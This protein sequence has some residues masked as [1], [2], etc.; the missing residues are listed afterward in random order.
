MPGNF[1]FFPCQIEGD[2]AFVFVDVDAKDD[3]AKAPGTLVRVRLMYQAPRANGLP[4]GAEFD[5]ARAIEKSLERFAQRARDRY[6]GRIT[7]SGFREFHVYSRQSKAAWQKFL[8]GLTRRSGY[9]LRLK[10]T[11]DR[12]HRAYLRSLYPTP[13]AWQVIS[14]IDVVTVLQREGDLEGV[15]RRI[16]H[17]SYFADARAAKRFAAWA[18]KNGFKH[19]LRLS[20][21]GEDGETCVRLYHVGPTQQRDLSRHSIALNR[22]AAALGGRYDGWETKVVRRNARGPKAKP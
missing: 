11:S 7:R 17:W 21:P 16:D 6:V 15:R 8:A 1:K 2:P 22:H 3:I 5:A 19:D 9:Q 12:R 14:D 20:G 10:V 13:D 18:V 4:T